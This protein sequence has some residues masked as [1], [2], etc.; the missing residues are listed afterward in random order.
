MDR[1]RR[2]RIQA[3][4]AL[5]LL[6]TS[7]TGC[8]HHHSSVQLGLKR[9]SLDLAFK[10]NKTP[11]PIQQVLTQPQT[12]PAVAELLGNIQVPATTTAPTVAPFKNQFAFDCPAAGPDV[13]PEKPATVFVTTPPTLGVY[14]VHNSGTF[15]L[16]G[17]IKLSGPYPRRTSQEIANVQEADTKDFSGNTNGRT[18]SYDV[19]Q[20]NPLQTVTTSYKSVTQTGGGGT[21][22]LDLT[23]IVTKTDQG[24]TTFAPVPSITIMQYKGEGASWNSAGIDPGTGTVMVVQG[25]VAKKEIVDV[26]GQLVDT[27]RVVSTEQLSN[28][29]GQYNSKT[30][31]NDPNV[32]N[33]ATQY[34]GLMVR[35]HIDTTTTFTVNNAPFTLTLNYTSTND[36]I[37]PRPPG[38]PPPPLF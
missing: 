5:A 2:R 3:V 10:N 25:S 24:T 8:V 6:A 35:Q 29:Q 11:P 16:D 27:Y 32:Y 15:K 1:T 14:Y 26:C 7:L 30:D 20:K 19:I 9:I 17:L 21:N 34:G 4:P 12:V 28:V 22:E 23:K 18:I 33:V 38:T 36:A 13:V 37:T 31:P